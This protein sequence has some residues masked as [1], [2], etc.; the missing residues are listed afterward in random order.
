VRAPAGRAKPARLPRKTL[1]YIIHA[2]QRP[3]RAAGRR[4]R[5]ASI[6]RPAGYNTSTPG[7]SGVPEACPGQPDEATT[8]D[9]DI[10]ARNTEG[11]G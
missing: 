11:L 2:P 3:R 5:T 8:A 6:R 4:R 10:P 1:R 9:Y 7:A